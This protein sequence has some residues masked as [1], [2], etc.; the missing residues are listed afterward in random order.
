MIYDFNDKQ[1]NRSRKCC[2][3]ISY[4]GRIYNHSDAEAAKLAVFKSMGHTKAGLW[5]N[6]T[7]EVRTNTAKL[8]VCMAPFDGWPEDLTACLK[9]VKKSCNGYLKYEPTDDEALAFFQAKYPRTYET[10]RN[11]EE[12]TLL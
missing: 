3:G 11:K 5:S 8:I 10:I 1:G 12:V 9:H 7:W 4:Q 6:T 2:Y